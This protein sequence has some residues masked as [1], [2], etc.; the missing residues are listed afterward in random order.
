[1]NEPENPVPDM[2]LRFLKMSYPVSRIKVKTKF[3]RGV[4]VNGEKFLLPKHNEYLIGK[5]YQ[6]LKA[7]Y[8]E[9]HEVIKTALKSHYGTSM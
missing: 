6:I 7:V 5:V 3:R 9:D 1:M 8:C 4:D 2:M